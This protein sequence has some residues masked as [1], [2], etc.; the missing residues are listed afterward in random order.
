V[1][2]LRAIYP[3]VRLTCL[4]SDHCIRQ[5][6]QSPDHST[7]TLLFH[8]DDPIHDSSSVSWAADQIPAS[9]YECSQNAWDWWTAYDDE[10]Q[11]CK[12]I[13]ISEPP[14]ILDDLPPTR[15]SFVQ[16]DNPLKYIDPS[17]LA[18][19]EHESLSCS[20]VIS[21]P[22]PETLAEFT[23]SQS[24]LNTMLPEI[25][26]IPSAAYTETPSNRQELNHANSLFSQSASPTRSD[27]TSNDTPEGKMEIVATRARYVCRTCQESFTTDRQYRNHVKT[28]S[29]QTSFKCHDC[30]RSFKAARSLQRHRGTTEAASCCPKVKTIGTQS[31]PFGCKRSGK[32]YTRKDSLQR[33]LR[34]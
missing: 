2:I 14:G 19:P 32:A 7:G 18:T 13:T 22:V 20:S 24:F 34:T 9:N 17:L 27:Q 21:Q 4:A 5:Y 10:L 23:Q 16:Y 31:K 12:S 11:G 28:L 8:P 29:C 33:Y 3:I 1:K 15:D 26:R 25:Q 30:G 6:G